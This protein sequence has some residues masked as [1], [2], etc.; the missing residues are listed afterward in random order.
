MATLAKSPKDLV[1]T[2]IMTWKSCM[3]PMCVHFQ[4][5]NAYL[6]DEVPSTP[7]N[8]ANEAFDPVMLCFYSRLTLH[9]FRERLCLTEE[10]V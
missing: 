9:V 5:M 1:F 8:I 7:L 6:V 4:T 10:L 2:G 3:T